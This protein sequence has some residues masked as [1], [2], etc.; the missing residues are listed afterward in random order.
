MD[1]REV[2]WLFPA[3]TVEKA[4]EGRR[5]GISVL[6]HGLLTARVWQELR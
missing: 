6:D 4:G 2:V 5:L 3:K 1:V